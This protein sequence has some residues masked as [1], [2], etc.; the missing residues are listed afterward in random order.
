MYSP[1]SIAWII[2]IQPLL[3]PLKANM[4]P[5]AFPSF[6]CSPTSQYC[7]CSKLG[8]GRY[9]QKRTCN[10]LKILG[11]TW[12]S[13]HGRGHHPDGV[14]QSYKLVKGGGGECNTEQPT[15]YLPSGPLPELPLNVFENLSHSLCAVKCILMHI[16]DSFLKI[17]SVSCI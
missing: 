1:S 8:I 2:P 16:G 14:S 7:I 9:C 6:F 5:P 3:L 4:Q 13:L 12:C 11:P 10:G 15:V 17:K